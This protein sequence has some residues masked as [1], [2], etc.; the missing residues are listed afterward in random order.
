MLSKRETELIL[1]RFFNDSL[2]FWKRMVPDERE[3]Y[4][5][6]IDDIKVVKR[7]PFSPSGDLLNEETKEKFIRY[8][9]Q[10]LG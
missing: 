7:D 5:N 2:K 4:A 9:I 1:E 3:A 8:K 10:N 6:A